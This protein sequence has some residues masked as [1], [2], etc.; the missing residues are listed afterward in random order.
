MTLS[1]GKYLLLDSCRNRRFLGMNALLVA[2]I[3]LALFFPVSGTAEQFLL[4]FSVYFALPALFVRF[5]LRESLSK[6]GC[7]WGK[8]G[9][10]VNIIW[11]FSGASLFGV[12]VWSVLHFTSFGQEFL[13]SSQSSLAALHRDFLIFLGSL[14][15]LAWFIFL[16]EVFFRGFFL[17]LW[18][19]FL[20]WKSFVAHFLL[21]AIVSAQELHVFAHADN[22]VTF[23][24][25][26]AW[27]TIASIIAFVTESVFVS[28]CF[29]LFSAILVSVLAI[30]L[31]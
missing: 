3:F 25:T 13:I 24:F 14:A 4:A 31:S 12:F 22:R 19:R 2:G 8:F 21:V 1:T 6:Y 29:S 20:L 11:I 9:I 15:F 27:S 7:S 18:K 28:F 30:S 16:K 10:V 17:L 5:V 23:L 26:L